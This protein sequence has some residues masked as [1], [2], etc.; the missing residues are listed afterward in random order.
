MRGRNSYKNF[1]VLGVATVL[2]AVLGVAILLPTGRS[3]FPSSRPRT[4]QCDDQGAARPIAADLVTAIRNADVQAI[5]KLLADGADVNGRDEAGNTPLILASFYATP[6]CI[7]LLIENG[8]DVNA[9]NKVGATPL[10]RAATSYEKAHVLVAAGANVRARSAVGN[11]P[12]L[13][14]ARRAGNSR[15]VRLLLERGADATERS[16]ADLSPILSGAASGDL[17][18]VCLLLD[19]GAKADDFPNANDLRARASSGFRTPL[20]W[21]AYHNDVR[22]A[23]LLLDHGADANQSTSFGNPLSH[24]CWSDSALAADLLIARGANVN[25]KDALAN[26]TPLHWA[27][28]T[29]SPNPRLVQVLLAHGAD[30]NAA[31]GEPV[32]AFGLVPQTPRLIAQKRGRTEI[33]AALVAAGAKVPPPA[34][35]IA[36]PHRSLPDVLDNATLIAS[37]EKALAALQTTAA[38]SRES[39]VRHVSKQDCASCHQQYLPMAAVGH[40]RNRSVRFDQ[41][42]AREQIDSLARLTNPAFDREFIMQTLMHPDP[43]HTLGYHL[44]GFVAEA[45]P[46]SVLTDGMVHH[47]VTVQASDGRWFNNLP[48]PPMQSSDVSATAMAIHAIKHYGWLGRKEEFAASVERARRWLWQVK[49]E[50]NEEAVFRLLGLHWAGEP[51]EKLADLARALR[52]QQ[53]KDGGWAQLT[54]LESDAYA[55]GEV[56]YTLAQTVND[57]VS[58]PAWQRGLRFL[59][60]RQEDDGTWHVMRRTFPFQPTMDSGFP[61]HRDSWISAA[62][63]SWAVLALTRTLPVG[64]A[65]SKPVAIR[66]TPQVPLP[67]TWQKIDFARQIKPL[68][69]RSCTA[70]HSGEKPRGFFLIDGR[71]A[72]LKGGASGDAVI[73]PGHSEKSSLIDRV[74]GKVPESEMPPKA[75]LE[76]FPALTADEVRLLR[77]WI[78]QGAEWPTG[79]LLT[80]PRIE[81]QR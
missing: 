22:M 9:A 76:R 15:T 35:K 74:S 5:G 40:A 33:V 41:E 32:G 60:E 6:E 12:L 18:T 58:D 48:R 2:L 75:V 81:P 25:A 46:P 78:D 44:F 72:I 17:K 13:L 45:V 52:Q 80:S 73:V 59:L 30:P 47:L 34:E 67:S 64:P 23:R 14:A 21:A 28:G 38:K 54:T 70:C 19:A 20:M 51:P 1:A 61:H 53:R 27:A 79:M 36:T 49:A 71:D 24:A 68:L 26:F 3:R 39:F 62:A 55:S 69:E 50:T 11:T 57:A 10:I 63:T 56:L 42:A 16:A 7:Q 65:N 66:K 37:T 77:A 29:E 4:V 31:G 8:A 43:A